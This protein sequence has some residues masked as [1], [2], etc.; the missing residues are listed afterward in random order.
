MTRIRL[1]FVHAFHDRHGKLRHYFRRPGF[2]QTPLV[3]PPGSAEFMEAYQAA[4]AGLTP[5]RQEVGAS[6]TKPGTVNAAVVGYYQSLA[7]RSLALVTQKKRRAILERFRDLAGD[8]SIATLRREDAHR[9]LGKMKP[10][11]ARNWLKTLRGLLVFAVAEG[12][13]ADDPTHGIKLQP[14]K[15]AGIPTWT[16]EEIAQFEAHYPIGTKARLA[17]ALLLDTAQRTGD[18]VR[19]GRQHVQSGAIHIRQNKTGETLAIPIYPSLQAV[20]DAT[21]CALHNMTFLMTVRGKPFTAAGFGDWFRDRCNEAGLPKRCT[22]HGLRKAAAR[23]LAE[24]G[25][26][27]HQIASMTGHRSLSEVQR[28]TS[29]ANQAKLA[30]EAVELRTRRTKSVDDSGKPS[31]GFAKTIP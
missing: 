7:F 19:M 1:Q 14:L 9:L 15:S 23:R 21:P 31:I 12:F 16:E 6:R 8:K 28:Y 26:T 11:A 10:G 30:R 17:F 24:E 4:L 2:K 27:T 3:G 29:A 18:V 13:R 20:L 22:A 25:A 5:P